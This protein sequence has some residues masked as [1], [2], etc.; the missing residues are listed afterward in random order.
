MLLPSMLCWHRCGTAR[1]QGEAEQW[2]A[3][4]CNF[5][6]AQSW[7][8]CAGG[9]GAPESE[10]NNNNNTVCRPS[11]G[12]VTRLSPDP[13]QPSSAPP[14]HIQ[15]QLQHHHGTKK[16]PRRSSAQRGGGCR[17]ISAH[18]VRQPQ[19][20]NFEQLQSSRRLGHGAAGWAGPRRAGLV[21]RG[22]RV[23]APWV[24]IKGIDRQR[25]SA[26]PLCSRLQHLHRSI[27][28]CKYQMMAAVL[29]Y[30]DTAD[31]AA[32]QTL[33]HWL[34]AP[35]PGHT[36]PETI[37]QRWLV[38]VVT[39]QIVQTTAALQHRTCSHQ[40]AADPLLPETRT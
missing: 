27:V 24:I 38:V 30:K 39:G 40:P 32:L 22:N 34:L 4:L 7:S 25:Y 21:E 37:Y 23:G 18:S 15:I 13:A 35:G 12:A 33:Q 16:L 20:C 29:Q 14:I 28:H 3:D 8:A 26:T 1:T 10:P 5:T 17:V 31:T 9:G 11:T 19:F 36:K 6:P 2:T